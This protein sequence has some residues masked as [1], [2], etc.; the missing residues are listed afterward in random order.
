MASF[1]S[2]MKKADGSGARFAIIVGSD[3]VAQ[4]MLSMKDLR[5]TD[6]NGASQQLISVDDAAAL[7]LRSRAAP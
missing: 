2:Q 3:E 6:L 1:K 5:G 7:A 4:S